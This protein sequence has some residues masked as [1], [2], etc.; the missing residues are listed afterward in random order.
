MELYLGNNCIKD[1]KEIIKLKALNRLIILDI[2]GN[3]LSF[4]ANYR[5]FCIFNLKK[6]KV[7]DGVSIE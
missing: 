4:D 1:I 3:N 6:L 7:L 5:I 2:L